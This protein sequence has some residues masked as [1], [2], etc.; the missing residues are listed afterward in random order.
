MMTGQYLH[1]Y[2]E[3]IGDDKNKI[4]TSKMLSDN[5]VI[6]EKVLLIEAHGHTLDH[7]SY[8]WPAKCW[9]HSLYMSFMHT[10]TL[11]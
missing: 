5:L 4:S 7:I 6:K 10:Q 9:I 1:T 8:L 3:Y 11:K 2:V